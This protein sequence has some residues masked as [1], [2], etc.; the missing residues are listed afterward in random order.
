MPVLPRSTFFFTNTNGYGWSET[1]FSNAPDL[2]SAMT[3]AKAM[4]VPRV[5]LLGRGSSLKFIRVSDDLIK[6]DSQI[7]PVPEDDG[8][9]KTR[10]QSTADIANTC[11]LLRLEAG[12]R[13]RRPL[14]LRGIPDEICDDNGRYIPTAT[15]QNNLQ[16]W[17]VAFRAQGYCV[18]VRTN[19]GVP[20][21]ITNV[22]TIGPT[23]LV[24]I[25]TAAAHGFALN[26][27]V[28][29]RAVLGAT[30]VRGLHQ[31]VTVVDATS[32]QIRISR[33]VK[34]YQSN[35]NVCKVTYNT[36][37]IVTFVAVRC[38]HHNA[39]RPFDSPVGRRRAP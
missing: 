3:S 28:N 20:V 30:Q 33:V 26:D 18:K 12:D 2:A 13:W 34:P 37:S 35:G 23:G 5:R 32:F 8:T 15:F 24:T 9:P 17:Q 36:P 16:I 25:T 4:I 38:T 22:G 1:F 14:F 27:V 31:V 11:L 39:G 29:I 6:R 7:Y 21:N 10:S 19:D